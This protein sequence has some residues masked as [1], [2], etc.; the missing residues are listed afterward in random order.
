MLGFKEQTNYRRLLDE[1]KEGV[2]ALIDHQN[3]TG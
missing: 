1:A 2:L 3:L